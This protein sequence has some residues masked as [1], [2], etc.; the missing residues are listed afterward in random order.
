MTT[1]VGSAHYDLS[2]FLEK[3]HIV[4]SHHSGL[5]PDRFSLMEAASV[6]A[7]EK[8]SDTPRSVEA[9][10]G[11]LVSI[12][13]DNV[14]DATRQRLK[15]LI[16]AMIGTSGDHKGSDRVRALKKWLYSEN[17]PMWLTSSSHGYEHIPGIVKQAYPVIMDRSPDLASRNNLRIPINQARQ[18]LEL[19]YIALQERTE[20][21]YTMA[22]MAP[23]A[24]DIDNQGLVLTA[25]TLFAL[26][27]QELAAIVVLR[28][29]PTIHSG[30]FATVLPVSVC[31]GVR[32]NLLAGRYN[33]PLTHRLDVSVKNALATCRTSLEDSLVNLV[34]EITEL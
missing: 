31:N 18:S 15:P 32:H 7:Q 34:K 3:V 23:L 13:A 12:I 11:T 28:R 25:Q 2:E 33:T 1:P 17:L 9:V 20:R 16:P 30:R 24:D 19:A 22:M 8:R 27:A 14:T 5:Y 4:T 21:A 6:V 10:L 26:C 29:S